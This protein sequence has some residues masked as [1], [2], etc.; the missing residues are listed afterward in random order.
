MA[1][2]ESDPWPESAEQVSQEFV[3]CAIELLD[4]V[5]RDLVG[6]ASDAPD[7]AAERR[8]LESLAVL[9]RSSAFLGLGDVVVLCDR[10]TAETRSA[11]APGQSSRDAAAEALRLVHGLRVGLMQPAATPPG[12]R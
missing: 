11:D 9:R 2:T 10:V 1:S 7:S 12:S 6:L 3:R 5:E 4:N 8:V